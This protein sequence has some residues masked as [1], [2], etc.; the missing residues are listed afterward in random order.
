MAATGGRSTQVRNG[1]FTARCAH[2]RTRSHRL[3]VPTIAKLV[4]YVRYRTVIY[5]KSK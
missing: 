5:S 4:K 3:C 2:D 1:P